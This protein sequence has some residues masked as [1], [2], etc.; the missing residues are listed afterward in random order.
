MVIVGNKK[1]ET[2]MFYTS[3]VKL[4]NLTDVVD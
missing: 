4:V 1:N 2:V 3:I